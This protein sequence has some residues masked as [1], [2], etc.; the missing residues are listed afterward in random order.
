ME[1]VDNINMLYNVAVWAV[2]A[3]TLV[4]LILYILYQTKVKLRNTY[5]EFLPFVINFYLE[6]Y[7]D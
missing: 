6:A 1:S 7:M 5:V 4:E 2:P 3:L